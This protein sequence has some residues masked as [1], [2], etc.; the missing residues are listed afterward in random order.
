MKN[1]GSIENPN[2]KQELYL[3]VGVNNADKSS[4]IK[5]FVGIVI[6]GFGLGIIINNAFDC[7]AS[8]YNRTMDKTLFELGLTDERM[9]KD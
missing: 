2:T 4:V 7:G 9:T 8:A 5:C 1:Y 3:D 6:V